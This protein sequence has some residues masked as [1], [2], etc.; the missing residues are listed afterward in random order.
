MDCSQLI[1]KAQCGDEKS[2]TRLSELVEQYLHTCIYRLT[3]DQTATQDIVQETMLEMVK[4]L[5]KLEKPDSFWSWLRKIATHKI[6]QQNKKQQQH[7]T[8]P[9]SDQSLANARADG[10]AA[11]ANLVTKEWQQIVFAAMETLKQRHRQ[12]LV[13][14]CYEQLG[15]QEIAAEM[16]CSQFAARM[17]FYRA[18]KVLARQLSRR[19]L[20]RGSLLAALVLFGKMTAPTQTAAAQLSVG[21]ATLSAGF[22]AGA[23]AALVSKTAILSVGTT[24]IITAG[25]L[26]AIQTPKTTA[27]ATGKQPSTLRPAASPTATQPENCERWYYYPTGTSG[28]VMTRIIKSTS[29]SDRSYCRILQN[30]EAN[31]SF[32]RQANTVFLNNYRHWADDLA[33]T[34]LP[35]DSP[36]LTH[37]L[38]KT[39]ATNTTFQ[40]I[41]AQNDAFLVV[42]ENIS[43]TSSTCVIDHRTAS[44][45][46]YFLFNWPPAAKIVDR[47]DQMHKRGW[48][49]FTVEGRI[50]GRQVKGAGRIPFVYTAY[51][52]HWPWMR[53]RIGHKSFV[54]QSFAGLGRPWMGLHTIDTIRRD[55][56]E[57]R[58]SFDT[59]LF[60]ENRKAQ[61]TLKTTSAQIVYTVDMESDVV[62]RIDFTDTRQG[63]L[64]FTYLQDVDDIGSDF[65]EPVHIHRTQSLF[66]LLRAD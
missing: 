51:K 41:T 7:K 29:N 13:L 62:E 38:Q 8:V 19:G 37:L 48:T 12:V 45:E 63:E 16:H 39:N 26:I 10:Q 66:R 57:R 9:L 42:V 55:A 11:F 15:Y 59:K 47:R 60:A 36:G 25:S 43:K 23:A 1:R 53:L 33:V 58:I 65:T 17:L 61:V 20:G 6:Y 21:T 34:C 50:N 28:P 49:Y 56:A 22:T 3:L 24:A 27:P 2:L 30:A 40:P 46:Q 35:A 5:D 18:K 52:D 14:R 64:M 44:Q 54:D 31:Y 32:D 4:F